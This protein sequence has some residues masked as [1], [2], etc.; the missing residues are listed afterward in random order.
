[1]IGQLRGQVVHLESP[2][3]ATI[4]VG[5]VGYNVRVPSCSMALGDECIFWIHTHVREDA[6]ELYGFLELEDRVFF[7]Q[8]LTVTGV[9]PRCALGILGASRVTL[10]QALAT[11]DQELL[12]TLPGVGKKLAERLIVE[13]ADKV[14]HDEVAFLASALLKDLGLTHQE[15]AKVLQKRIAGQSAEDIVRFAL[16]TRHK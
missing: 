9:G 15:I 13:L 10:Q 3:S 16:K 14:Q 6:F 11:R 8:L 5:S 4:L 2:Q 1:M 7:R 12:R